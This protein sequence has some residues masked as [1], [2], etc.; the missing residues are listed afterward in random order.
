MAITLYAGRT[1]SHVILKYPLVEGGQQFL[2]FHL[3]QKRNVSNSLV[4]AGRF[5]HYE[6][7]IITPALIVSF[8]DLDNGIEFLLR[9]EIL[10]IKDGRNL[11]FPKRDLRE[12]HSKMLERRHEAIHRSKPRLVVSQ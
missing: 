11:G 10:L 8:S 4:N 12:V 6:L 1:S 3:L 7:V 5:L 2:Y 9:A